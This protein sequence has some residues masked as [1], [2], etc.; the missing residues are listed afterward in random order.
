MK[1]DELNPGIQM[2]LCNQIAANA[3]FLQSI[4]EPVDEHGIGQDSLKADYIKYAI[5]ESEM[6]LKHPSFKAFVSRL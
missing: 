5:E 6:V 3:R 2:L 1:I 4:L